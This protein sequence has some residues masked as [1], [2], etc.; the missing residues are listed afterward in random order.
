MS[1]PGRSTM[2]HCVLLGV[3][4]VL[5]ALSRAATRAPIVEKVAKK[6]GLDSLGQVDAIRY[7]FHLAFP[8]VNVSRSWVWEPKTDRVSFAGTDKDGKP[9]KATYLRS[10]L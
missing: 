9:V 7:T 1:K 8:G 10:T 3:L 6:Y 5:A 4:L 2:I